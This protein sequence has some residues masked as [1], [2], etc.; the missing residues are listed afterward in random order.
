M[1]MAMDKSYSSQGISL[2]LLY[3]LLN[4]LVE[5]MIY[6]TYEVQQHLFTCNRSLSNAFKQM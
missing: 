4:I 1:M 3:R 2:F 5:S 6:N